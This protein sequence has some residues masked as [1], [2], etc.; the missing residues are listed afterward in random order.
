LNNTFILITALTLLLAPTPPIWAEEL[1]L[2]GVITDINGKP[3]AGAEV[4]LYRG[5]N[6]KKP[7]DFSSNRTNEDGAYTV[8]VP[9]STYWAVAVLRKGEKRF[10]PLELGDKHSGEPVEVVVAPG[11]E[12]KHDFTVMDLREAAKQ[13]QKKNSDLFR[14]SGRV[15]DHNS[16]P[17][18]MAYAMADRSERFKDVPNYISPWSDNSGAFL[19]YLPKGRYFIG[20]ATSYPPDPSQPLPKEINVTGDMEGVDLVLQPAVGQQIK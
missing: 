8:T 15:L 18:A 12:L 10:G 6:I 11:G 9:P 17:L 14:L 7:A 2:H 3:V 1:A 16:Q 19:L 20:A 5:K 4:A 13:N